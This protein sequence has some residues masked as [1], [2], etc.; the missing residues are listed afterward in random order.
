MGERA[1]RIW[2]MSQEKAWG[3]LRNT[4]RGLWVERKWV[5]ELAFLST[6]SQF[7]DRT[8]KFAASVELSEVSSLKT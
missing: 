7:Q 5:R 1:E 4:R 6:P 8:V 2:A 3:S